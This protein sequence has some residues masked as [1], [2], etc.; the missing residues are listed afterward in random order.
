M[1][2]KKENLSDFIMLPASHWARLG[3]IAQEQGVLGVMLDGIDRL[4]ATGY[5]ATRELSK[6]QKLDWIG[7]VSKSY[8]TRNQHQLAVII[9]LQKR[10]ADSGLRMMVMKGQAIGT[11]YPTTQNT[12][13]LAILT[14]IYLMGTQKAMKR[15]RNGQTL[16][17][18]IGINIR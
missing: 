6:G 10:W 13:P 8:E 18:S 9:D 12:G 11:F 3:E 15:P 2:Q 17:M 1:S 16:L 14:V 7:N 4:E 5:G